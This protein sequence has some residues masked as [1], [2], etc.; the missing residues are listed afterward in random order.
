MGVKFKNKR[1]TINI[2]RYNTEINWYILFGK[3]QKRRNRNKCSFNQTW[4][5]EDMLSFCCY[6]LKCWSDQERTFLHWRGYH[7]LFSLNFSTIGPA[8][9]V[10]I[11]MPSEATTSSKFL[12][13]VIFEWALSLE[14]FSNLSWCHFYRFLN[15]HDIWANKTKILQKS[16]KKLAFSKRWHF[17]SI[18]PVWWCLKVYIG[19][20]ILRGSS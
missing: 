9:F 2:K 13:V 11:S 7:L 12:L 6:F 3:T 5:L 4:C 19:N 10:Y 20:F 18:I 16:Q 8:T 15:C 14:N 1:Y 17:I